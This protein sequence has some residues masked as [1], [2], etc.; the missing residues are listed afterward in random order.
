MK[1]SIILFFSLLYILFSG[2][3]FTK[4]SDFGVTLSATVVGPP[5]INDFDLSGINPDAKPVND[6]GSVKGASTST[7][8]DSSLKI[9]ALE[10]GAVLLVVLFYYFMKR[11][12]QAHI[13]FKNKLINNLA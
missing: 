5:T 13:K 10:L 7:N 2:F 4:A 12:L 1:L 3:S 11:R 8:N 6:K 9:I